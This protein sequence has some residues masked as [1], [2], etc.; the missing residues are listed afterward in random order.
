[1]SGIKKEQWTESQVVALPAGEHNYFDRKSGDLLT[2]SDFRLKCAKALS[3]FANSGGGHLVLGVRDDGT[4]DGVAP[5]RGHTPTREWIEQIIPGLLSYPLEDFRVHEVVPATPSAITSGTVIIVIDV[6]D[7]ALAPH[8]AAPN[9]T[10][11]YREGGHS[12]PAPHFYLETLRNRLVRP[13]LEAE[14]TGIDVTRANKFNDG[15][16]VEMVLNFQITNKGRVAAY[17]W[18]LSIDEMS[19]H[20]DGREDDYKFSFSSFPVPMKGLRKSSIRIDDTILPS[21]ALNEKRD[22]GLQLR[23]TSLSKE[24]LIEDLR[25][26]ISAE[27]KLNF[28]VVSETSPGELRSKALA[29]LIDYE[30]F[31]ESLFSVGLKTP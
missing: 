31:V 23:P 1:M 4:F 5:L 20:F 21:L 29:D 16:F 24:H 6:G 8:Q 10:Y 12:K 3:A 30:E 28:R 27:F 11:Y 19:G 13:S 9:K 22:F 15:V 25:T 17:K 26:T 14:L 2:G 7:S 18:E